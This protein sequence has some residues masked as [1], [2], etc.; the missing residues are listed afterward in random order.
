[1]DRFSEALR[2]TPSPRPAELSPG[3]VP[4][5]PWQEPAAPSPRQ[6]PPHRCFCPEFKDAS[7]SSA[8]AGPQ[9]ILINK[10]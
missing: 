1:M 5:S 7:L 4:R 8:S 9:P 10:V 6:P 3:D 2:C